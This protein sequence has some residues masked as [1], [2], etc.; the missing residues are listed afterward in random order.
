[1]AKIPKNIKLKDERVILGHSLQS[2]AC[3]VSGPVEMQS[4]TGKGYSK[5]KAGHFMAARKQRKRER[6]HSPN[7]PFKVTLTIMYF[8]QVVSTF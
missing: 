1:V 5:S 4:T 7:V 8:L 6:G 3:L 2:F